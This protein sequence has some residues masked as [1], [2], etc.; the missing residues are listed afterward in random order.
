MIGRTYQH[1]SMGAW[2]GIGLSRLV[3]NLVAT[4]GASSVLVADSHAF[5][6]N[7]LA[8]QL[9]SR[10]R[11]VS[12]SPRTFSM[13]HGLDSSFDALLLVGFH[14]AAGT[15]GVMAHTLSGLAFARIEIDRR[16]VGEVELFGGYAAELGVPLVVVTGDNLVAAETVNT[17]PDTISVVVKDGLGGWACN[18]LSPQHAREKIESAIA[19]GLSSKPLA[20]AKRLQGTPFIVTVEMTRQ[21][22]AD[23]CC[24]LP[25]IKRLSATRISFESPSYEYAVRILQALSWIVIGVQR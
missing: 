4:A 23:A 24:L 2:F 1:A 18:S 16:A 20:R 9:D 3:W 19:S 10:A 6:Q 8:D 7:I 17:F 21:F 15:F 13:L 22:F 25:D 12:G 14:A 5:M 11:L